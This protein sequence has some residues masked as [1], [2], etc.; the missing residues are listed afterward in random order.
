MYQRIGYGKR[1]RIATNEQSFCFTFS[2]TWRVF[3][4]KQE[5]EAYHAE[6]IAKHAHI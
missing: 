5:S 3:E 4:K 2:T 1:R 6:P